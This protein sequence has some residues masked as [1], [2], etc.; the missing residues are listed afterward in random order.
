MHDFGKVS[1]QAGAKYTTLLPENL[2]RGTTRLEVHVQYSAD[3]GK[4]WYEVMSTTTPDVPIK[5]A[6]LEWL[7]ALNPEIA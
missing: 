1:A 3:G 6:K 7:V 4:T 5:D 2:P